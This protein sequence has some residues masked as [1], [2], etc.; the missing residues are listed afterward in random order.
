LQTGWAKLLGKSERVRGLRVLHLL[1][2]WVT[3]QL[4]HIAHVAPLYFVITYFDHSLLTLPIYLL[5]LRFG[6]RCGGGSGQLGK[7]PLTWLYRDHWVNHH[8]ELSFIYCHAPHHDA[9]PSAM[10]GCAGDGIL[11][12]FIRTWVWGKCL[13]EPITASI[14]MS[15][16]VI[17]DMKQHQ[18]APGVY[19]YVKN[20]LKAGNHHMEHHFLKL[21][22]IGVDIAMLPNQK[23]WGMSVWLDGFNRKNE[24]WK[25]W[26]EQARAVEIDSPSLLT[27]NPLHKVADVA[28]AD[29]QVAE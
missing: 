10:I 3:G 19:P 20:N 11:G 21:N 1:Q 23:L 5:N 4:C 15:K 26:S 16:T 14:L 2:A 24:T 28:D 13:D 25:W 8:S 9:I 7:G 29:P 18:Y 12:L 22:P 27:T 6:R 17:M